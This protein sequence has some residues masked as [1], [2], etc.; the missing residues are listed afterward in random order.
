MV[1]RLFTRVCCNGTSGNVSKLKEGRHG[2]VTKKCFYKKGSEALEQRGGGSSV[3]RDIQGE[4]GPGP[5]QP[6]LAVGAPVQCR[7]VE[8]DDLSGSFLTQMI[9]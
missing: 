7:G 3:P 5:E 4:V 2:L 6:D 1:V 8:L 9:L